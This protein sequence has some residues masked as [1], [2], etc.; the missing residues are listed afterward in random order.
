MNI[1]LR[2][3]IASVLAPY[4]KPI[5]IDEIASK[6]VEAEGDLEKFGA[7]PLRSICSCLEDAIRTEG[8]SC[9]FLKSFLGFYMLREKA[10]PH[11]LLKASKARSTESK[12]HEGQL[13]IVSCFGVSWQR[14][15]VK[16]TPSPEILGCQF[17]ASK[18]INFGQQIGF[19]AL[20]S[21]GGE[22]GYFASTI[23]KPIGT[24][25]FEHTQNRLRGGGIGSHSSASC[26]SR[27]PESLI[28]CP[29][30][31]NQPTRWPLL[32]PSSWNCSVPGATDCTLTGSQPLSSSSGMA[33]RTVQHFLRPWTRRWLLKKIISLA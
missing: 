21:E 25:L 18:P 13:G 1:A 17:Q 27:M 11:Q 16:W 4:S 14:S 10:K 8:E 6:L 32:R 28:G 15:R 30:I 24:C 33:A 5:D 19:Y 20:H 7:V 26:L 23:D 31:S 9:P 3:S 22:V 2:E 12:F 29:M